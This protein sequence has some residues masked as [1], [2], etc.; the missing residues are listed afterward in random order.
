MPLSPD[1]IF[2]DL[3]SSPAL[4]ETIEKWVARLEHLEPR[5]HRIQVVVELPHRHQRS[6]QVFHVR[7][8]IALPDRTI[9]VGREPEI[10]GAHTDAYV[11]IADAFRAA[12]RQL[13]DVIQIRRG[14]VKQPA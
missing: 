2:R 3:P 10:D 12:R 13:Q 6:G 5:I 14:D 4:V 11:A 7:L 9:V 8:E 1:I